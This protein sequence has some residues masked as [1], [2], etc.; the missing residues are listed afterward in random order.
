M[1]YVNINVIRMYIKITISEMKYQKKKTKKGEK[2]VSKGHAYSSMDN[3]QIVPVKKGI[4]KH[5]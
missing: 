2:R 1:E 5:K 3:F 4:S